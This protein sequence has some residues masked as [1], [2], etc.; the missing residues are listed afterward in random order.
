M[1]INGLSSASE[2]QQQFKATLKASIESSINI[3]TINNINSPQ[4]TNTTPYTN[5]SATE[6]HRDSTSSTHSTA[7]KS[8][9]KAASR[10]IQEHHRSVN[11]AWSAYYSYPCTPS[12]SAAP[13]RRPSAESTSSVEAVPAKTQTASP[14]VGTVE[15]QPRNITKLWNKVKEHNKSVN[16]AYSHYYGVN[17]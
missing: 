1:G 12:G 6:M 16:A 9:L 17:Y 4:T 5:M 8:A 14:A 7:V 3:T 13:T 10:R 11:A 2:H 15:D